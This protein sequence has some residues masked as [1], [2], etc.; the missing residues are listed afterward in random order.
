MS[1]SRAK[2]AFAAMAV[3]GALL[4]AL[5]QEPA[6]APPLRF[7]EPPVNQRADRRVEQHARAVPWRG[8]SERIVRRQG[9]PS[10]QRLMAEHSPEELAGP[11]MAAAR[12]QPGEF[13]LDE[14]ELLLDILESVENAPTT[15][16]GWEELALE[17]HP[18]LAMAAARV[19]A[20]EGRFVQAGLYPNPRVGYMGDEIGDDG[21][22]LLCC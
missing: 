13:L 17:R 18:G 10:R 11:V 15:L 2:T 20:A 1:V 8:E 12:Q 16:A 6:E 4:P 22:A 9:Q 14:R 7:P 5:A 21:A 19:R 3:L